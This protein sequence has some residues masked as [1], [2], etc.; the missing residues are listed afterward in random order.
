MKIKDLAIIN[1]IKII[2]SGKVERITNL[3]PLKYSR[4]N[5]LKGAKI[6]GK[7]KLVLGYK[8][9]PKTKQETRFSIGKNSKLNINGN[10]SAHASTDIRIFDGAELSI[11]SGYCTAD[12]QI[13]CAKKI[14]IGNHVAIARGVIIRDTDAH[15]II[16]K[17]H[18]KVKPVVIEDNV[19]IGN[20]SIIMKGVTIGSGAIVAAGAIVTKDVP[21]N[22]IVAGV[23]AKVIKE[24]VTWK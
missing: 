9:H 2:L 3:V 20:R 10:F 16:G 14:T 12:T 15:E 21:K 4:I 7:G 23:P 24:N 1:Y 19:W 11:G 5:I 13:V 17:D 6:H 22:T 8:E 18:E